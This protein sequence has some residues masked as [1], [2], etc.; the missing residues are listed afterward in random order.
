MSKTLSKIMVICALAV[1]V[2]LMVIG[3][4]FAAY[5]SVNALVSVGI[6]TNVEE[7]PQG[8]YAKVV[9]DGKE[10]D[11]KFDVNQSH[12]KKLTLKAEANG[13]NFVGWYDGTAKTYKA[14]YTVDPT[15][16]EYISDADTLEAKMTDYDDILAVF[17]L[18]T[19]TVSYSYKADPEGGVSTE[20]PEGFGTTL[21]YGQALPTFTKAHYTF[22]GWKVNGSTELYTR[23]NFDVTGDVALT[24]DD[25][26]W[27]Q[28]EQYTVKFVYGET[29]LGSIT[30]YD[31]ETVSFPEITLDAAG[32]LTT[33]DALADADRPVVEDGY[34]AVWKVNGTEASQATSAA[35]VTLVKEA[36]VYNV[37][38]N[39]VA[40]VANYSADKAQSVSFTV[41]NK[42]TALADVFAAANWKTQYSFWKFTGIK[43]GE[44]DIADADALGDAIIASSK[45]ATTSV[46]I[47][48]NIHKYFTRIATVNV[49]YRV[50]TTAGSGEFNKTAYVKESDGSSY[51]EATSTIELAEVDTTT[52]FATWLMAT[53]DGVRRDS[54]DGA[55]VSL[56]KIRNT[57]TDAQKGTYFGQE[58]VEDFA[59]INDF[60]EYLYT[61]NT[62]A[63][64]DTF[65]CPTFNVWFR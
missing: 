3:T 43:L 36:I 60:I 62:I 59:T 58:F 4:A 53:F 19:F 45:H 13:Y 7:N 33:F 41:E 37:S 23:A 42:A 65:A 1:I 9:Y 35:T 57:D 17:E 50:E 39:G 21:T 44:D 54:A 61:E 2:P 46:A 14:E 48:P 10:N 34:K 51:F 56:Y 15:Q 30:K 27:Q 49:L 55:N 63:D 22:K 24:V 52:S 32:K 5:Y 25:D 31:D 16:I 6:Y 38:V 8:A 28:A 64:A 18:K 12:L 11:T 29:E 26:C 20:V 40:G 47:T